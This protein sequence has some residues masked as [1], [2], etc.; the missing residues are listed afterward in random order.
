MSRERAPAMITGRFY[1]W[2]KY[3]QRKW[4]DWFMVVWFRVVSRGR[5][6]WCGIFCSL[7]SSWLA[8]NNIFFWVEE[9]DGRAA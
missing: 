5:S 2:S 8:W 1:Y 6:T 4:K 3:V 7:H 9:S